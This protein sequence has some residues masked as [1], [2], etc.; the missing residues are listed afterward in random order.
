MKNVSIRAFA[1]TIGLIAF[2]IAGLYLYFT[3]G[4][5]AVIDGYVTGKKTVS[6]GNINYWGKGLMEDTAGGAY[7]IAVDAGDD[8]TFIL[9]DKDMFPV[10]LDAKDIYNSITVGEFYVFQVRGVYLPILHIYP[11]IIRVDRE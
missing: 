4:Y 7:R 5:H 3:F 1:I 11:E 8:K 6:E 10:K 9:S 2:V